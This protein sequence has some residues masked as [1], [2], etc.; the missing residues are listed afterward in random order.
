VYLV[1]S[2]LLTVGFLLF[3]P[4]FAI[5]LFR[6]RKYITGLAQRL[7]RTPKLA[8]TTAPL[9]WLHCVSVG[10][11]EA[12]RPLFRALRERLPAHRLV[13]STTT[14]TGQAVARNAFGK[15]ATAIFYFPID[16]SWTVRRVLKALNPSAILIM[17]TELWPNLLRECGQR[18]IPVVLVNGRISPT[19][20]RRYRM[21]RG[22]MRMVLGDLR[23]AFMQSDDDA[24]RLIEL[25]LDPARITSVGN[26]K[27]DSAP[28]PATENDVTSEL[29]RRFAFNS[30]QQVI[31][32]ASTHSPE[33]TVAIESF[34]AVRESNHRTRLL[35]VPRHPE[36]FDEVAKLIE[37]S[38]FEWS[39]RSAP[40]SPSDKTSTIVLLDSIGELR[41]TFQFANIAFIGGSLIPHGGQNV[42]EPAAQGVCV[43]TG[44]HTHNFA[45]I[46]R[47]LLAED[48]L[49]QLP[50]LSIAE[51]PAALA[52]VINELLRDEA[53]RKAIGQ[54][55]QNVCAQNRGA[56]RQTVNMIINLLEPT[57]AVS[58]SLPFPTVEVTAT[59]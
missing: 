16:W 27:F 51:A 23:F 36:R 47:D 30:D 39:R 41:A 56:T 25:G 19:S 5:D 18:S 53:R 1:Y 11:T 46:T 49:I 13:V 12:A 8:S 10:E 3:L 45:A 20:F 32:A 29:R 2:L 48:A 40:P 42:L 52:R 6:S 22:F 50:K 58:H 14:V 55:A 34:K 9:I 4:R 24:Q 28:L 35:I 44:A 7:G 15:E 26:M 21:I 38:G 17:E 59:K 57:P 37:D 54:R 33:E 31:V 43:I